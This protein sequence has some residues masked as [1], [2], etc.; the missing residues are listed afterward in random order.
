MKKFVTYTATQ[1]GHDYHW[2]PQTMMPELVISMF[3]AFGV[4]T[5]NWKG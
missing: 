5:T 4:D 1:R 3:D 2:P